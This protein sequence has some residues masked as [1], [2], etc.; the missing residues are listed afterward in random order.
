MAIGSATDLYN[1]LTNSGSSP[2]H[3]EPTASKRR[4]ALTRIARTF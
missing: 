2:F 1:S 3:H 4:P